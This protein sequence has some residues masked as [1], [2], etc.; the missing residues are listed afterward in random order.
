MKTLLMSL[1]LIASLASPAR[2]DRI[3]TSLRLTVDTFAIP[4][5]EGLPPRVLFAAGPA[6]AEVSLTV[7]ALPSGGTAR[8]TADLPRSNWREEIVWE[9]RRTGNAEA[10]AVRA[11][12]VDAPPERRTTARATPN[13]MQAGQRERARYRLVGFEPGEYEARVRVGS[14]VS[15]TERFLVSNGDET[16]ELRREYARYKVFFASPDRTTLERNL[17][18]LARLDPLNAGPWIRL[19]DLAVGTEPLQETLTRYTNAREAL[20]KRKRHFQELGQGAVADAI[21][22]QEQVLERVQHVLPSVYDEKKG[23]SLEIHEG[24]QK[25]YLVVERRTGR[26]VERIHA[27]APRDER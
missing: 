3:V 26:V 9:I 24:I 11:E 10:A 1:A 25:Q 20:A 17:R 4:P 27:P 21:G 23:L 22:E 16:T 13:L 18:E 6:R 12:P 19:A 5:S 7:A 8:A 14:L 15:N 2:S